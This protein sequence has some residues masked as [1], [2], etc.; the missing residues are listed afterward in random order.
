[1]TQRARAP[2]RGRAG[3]VHPG[4][5]LQAPQL[6]RQAP[7]RRGCRWRAA[8]RSSSSPPT[9]TSGSE[10]PARGGRGGQGRARPLRRRHRVGALHLR[11][12]HRST[13]SWRAA[14]ARLV[15]NAGV[16]LSFVSCWNANEAV[17]GTLLGEDDLVLSDQ[18]NHASIID[19]VRLAKAITK[20]QTGGLPARRPRRP[21]REARRRAGPPGQAGD[22]RRRLLDGRRHRAAA[23]PARASAASTTRCWWWTTRTPP[24]CWARPGRGTAEHF[25]MVGEVDIITSTLGKA[26]GGAAGGF[27]AA[28]GGGLRLPHPAGAA[29]AL[30]QRAA[31]HRRGQLARQH[32]V[33][34]G[35]PGAGDPP[36]RERAATSASGSSSSAS[37][38]SR[39]RPRSFRSSS[40]RPRP[41]SG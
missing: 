25:G 7:G 31:A 5:R 32:R 13:A 20:C 9:T 17:P 24:A 28:L 21:R 36:A 23:R 37:S 11:H 2:A 12:L 15:G 3:A 34:R 16:A 22:H 8:A 14:C 35:A 4:R 19:G 1:M 27:V 6:P 18:L 29:A 33:P 26:L 39:A 41:P 30:L 40:A 10:Q 38:R